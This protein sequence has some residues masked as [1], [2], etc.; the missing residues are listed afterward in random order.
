MSYSEVRALP[1]RFR[2]WF[3]DRLAKEFKSQAEARRKAANSSQADRRTIV[4]DLPMG[5][6]N[7]VAQQNHEKKFK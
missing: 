6:M 5:E 2:A 4:Q 1:V 7:P 3:L